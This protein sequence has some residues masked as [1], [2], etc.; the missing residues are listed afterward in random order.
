MLYWNQDPNKIHTWHMFLSFLIYKLSLFLSFFFSPWWLFV[1][2]TKFCVLFLTI[3]ILLIPHTWCHL[4]ESPIP[5]TS[6]QL[7]VRSMMRFM[8]DFCQK[9][10]CGSYCITSEGANVCCLSFCEVQI[11]VWVQRPTTPSTNCEFPI[12]FTML[13]GKYKFLLPYRKSN[14]FWLAENSRF[15][16]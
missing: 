10:L 1:E 16:I 3:W 2:R 12:P 14:L 8:F 5:C 11:D 13:A 6:Y 9:V 7:G 15:Y 4:T